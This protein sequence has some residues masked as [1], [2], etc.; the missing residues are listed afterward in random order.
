MEV[1]GCCGGY[2][3][4]TSS[5]IEVEL[6]DGNGR[7]DGDQRTMAKRRSYSMVVGV[8][9]RLAFVFPNSDEMRWRSKSTNKAPTTKI[10]L[11]LGFGIERER[12]NGVG[13]RAWG[14]PYRARG[15][16]WRAAVFL[17][18]RQLRLELGRAT[19]GGCYWGGVELV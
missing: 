5:E 11:G 18:F 9:P 7:L 4:G 6:E 2:L 14:A 8:A 10:E 13:G 12:E 1:R 15:R 3:T 19:L 16:Q 17:G